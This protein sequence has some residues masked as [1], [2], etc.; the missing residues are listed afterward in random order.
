VKFYVRSVL[1]S[2]IALGAAALFVFGIYQVARGG[3]CASG[4]PYVSTKECAPASTTWMFVLPP[5]L[6]V[7]LCGLWLVKLRG[8]RPGAAEPALVPDL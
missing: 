5:V 3:T 2:L 8:P 1:G 4:G 7:G 6:L